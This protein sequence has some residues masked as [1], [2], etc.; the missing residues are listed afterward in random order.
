MIFLDIKC[1]E[2][3][4]VL[5]SSTLEL[6]PGGENILEACN[7]DFWKAPARKSGEEVEVTIDFKCPLRLELFSIINGFG[8]FGTEKFALFGSRNSS[9]PWT[10]LYRGQLPQG[11][12]MT[13]EV[14]FVIII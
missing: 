9:G 2:Q 10:K 13:E 11:V 6:L 12:E 5:S 4:E 7:N 3:K 8:N 14:I 1:P